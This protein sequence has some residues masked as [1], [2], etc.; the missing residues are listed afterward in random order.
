MIGINNKKRSFRET[1][2]S[3]LR[4]SVKT[5][6]IQEGVVFSKVIVQETAYS[7]TFKA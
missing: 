7:N 3:C 2:K 5:P 6:I 4:K 1:V